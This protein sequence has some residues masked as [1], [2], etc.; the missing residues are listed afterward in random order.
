MS[1]KASWDYIS[2]IHNLTKREPS[3]TVGGNGNCYR[4]YGEQY[5]GS[6]RKL[7]IELP[8]DP[9]IPLLAIYL[10]KIIIQK[11]PQ[12]SVFI[13]ALFTTVKTWNQP[14]CPLTEE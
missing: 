12:T 3:C 5:R 14:K 2:N 10:K 11:D 4:H 6:L 9:A 13:A 8:Y 7:K 1:E